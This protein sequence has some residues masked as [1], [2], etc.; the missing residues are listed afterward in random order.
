MKVLIIGG[1]GLIST[2]IVKHLKVRGAEI[3]MLNRGKRVEKLAEQ[4]R[5]LHEAG[6]QQITVDRDDV[7]AL[8]SQA[9]PGPRAAAARCERVRCAA[10][11]GRADA[12]VL[13]F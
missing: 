1:T 9:R 3:T 13:S 10:A 8:R 5:R 6:V 12:A 2:G 11:A 4:A 7:P